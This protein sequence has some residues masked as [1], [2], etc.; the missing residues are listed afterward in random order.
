LDYYFW[1]SDTTQ[2]VINFTA[3]RLQESNFCHDSFKI[4]ARLRQERQGAVGLCQII[5]V[6]VIVIVFITFHRSLQKDVE[7]VSEIIVLHF[8]L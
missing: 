6:I 5:I 2:E 4:L 8:M 7:I 3:R 1:A